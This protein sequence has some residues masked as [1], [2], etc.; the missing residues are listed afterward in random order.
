MKKGLKLI[1]NFSLIFILL[2]SICSATT[3]LSTC[4]DTDSGINFR[5]KGTAVGILWINKVTGTFTDYCQGSEVYEYSCREDGYVSYNLLYCPN[6]CSD[7]VCINLG[8]DIITT[9]LPN[10][11]AGSNPETDD[12]NE[13]TA[14][15]CE[16]TDGGDNK[17][18]FG[19]IY[20]PSKNNASEI[21]KL[22]DQCFLTT[23]AGNPVDSCSE[24]GC[25]ITE[26]FCTDEP[27]Y[28]GYY[29]GSDSLFPCPSGC[30]NGVCAGAI[31]EEEDEEVEGETNTI[32]SS[33]EPECEP[34]YFCAVEPATCPS[35]GLQTEYC[36]DI[37]CKTAGTVKE[38]SCTPE[39]CSGCKFEESCL[40]YGFRT[41][42]DSKKLYCDIDSELKEQKT[43]NADGN[44]DSCQNNFECA[45]NLCTEEECVNIQAVVGEAN[46]FRQ[47]F[48]PVFCKLIHPISEDEYNSCLY[49]YLGNI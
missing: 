17:K 22:Y 19:G 1:F 32:E 40:P 8:S 9:N 37:K 10:V 42:T 47:I 33:K 4:T 49:D 2:L 35:N 13:E 45:S 25:S 34:D 15:Q 30:N 14:N 44:W 27:N 28:N 36:S 5:A 3:V 12:S 24:E 39:S 20:Y 7:G 18:V 16:D 41:K 6:G 23:D 29:I 21:Y 26:Y 38:V 43:T 31:D 48:F 46:K 11:T